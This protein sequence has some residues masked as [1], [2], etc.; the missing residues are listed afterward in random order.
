M[1]PLTLWNNKSMLSSDMFICAEAADAFL[2]WM[3]VLNCRR[4]HILLTIAIMM[5]ADT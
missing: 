1:T 2:L 5:P 3:L 4:G